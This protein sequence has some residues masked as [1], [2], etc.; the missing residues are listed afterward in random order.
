M[1]SRRLLAGALLLSAAAVLLSGWHAP[2]AALVVSARSPGWAE[3][4]WSWPVGPTPIVLRAYRAPPTAYAAGHRGIDVAASVGTPVL[5][6]D[7]GVVSFTGAVGG[8]PVVAVTHAAGLVS[9]FEPVDALVAAGQA[10]RRGE[11]LG[12]LA[13]SAGHCPV[14][15]LHL[16]ARVDGRYVSPLVLL[17]VVP[18]AVLLPLAPRA[19]GSGVRLLVRTL[20]PLG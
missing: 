13:P 16:G 12:A 17:G 7:D 19:S 5:S 2:A 3:R 1:S 15:C 20:E 4:A 8:R 14:D 6:P 11:P 18:R 9:S 10:V